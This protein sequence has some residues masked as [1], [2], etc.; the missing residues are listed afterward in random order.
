MLVEH[1]NTDNEHNNMQ[2]LKLVILDK[3]V[4]P[5][6]KDKNQSWMVMS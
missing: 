1:Y 6:Y 3:G 5:I 4:C 2:K